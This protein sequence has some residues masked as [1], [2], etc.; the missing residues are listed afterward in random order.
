MYNTIPLPVD[1][2][3]I[4][5]AFSAF[6]F[7]WS[8]IAYYKRHNSHQ[9]AFIV[10]GYSLHSTPSYS[11]SGCTQPFSVLSLCLISNHLSIH[12][13]LLAAEWASIDWSL[14]TERVSIMVK[15]ALRPQFLV[16]DLSAKAVI[17]PASESVSHTITHTWKSFQLFLGKVYDYMKGEG[18][19]HLYRKRNLN[20]ATSRKKNEIVIGESKQNKRLSNP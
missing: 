2:V 1:H 3:L 11:L 9:H 16:H 5:G 7:L 12:L 14:L 8:Q 6:P 20:K 13:I 17:Q 10:L 4:Q 15:Y 18:K 19:S